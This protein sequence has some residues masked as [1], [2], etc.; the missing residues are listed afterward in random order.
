MY[1]SV[2]SEKSPSQSYAPATVCSFGNIC[3]HLKTKW[4]SVIVHSFYT[5]PS[6]VSYSLKRIVLNDSYRWIHKMFPHFLL[7]LNNIPQNEYTMIRT[8]TYGCES[9]PLNKFSETVIW[10]ALP[11]MNSVIIRWSRLD[12]NLIN[13]FLLIDTSSSSPFLLF[14]NTTEMKILSMSF[15]IYGDIIWKILFS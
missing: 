1:K 9:W 8:T 2:F 11:R 4:V 3:M 15:G 6:S 14:S 13:Q 7:G 12:S 5:I 10:M